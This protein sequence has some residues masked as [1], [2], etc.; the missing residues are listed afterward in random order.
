MGILDPLGGYEEAARLRLGQQPVTKGIKYGGKP[1]TIDR[2]K[3][4]REVCDDTFSHDSIQSCWRKSDI[5]PV[6][7]NADINNGVGFA[8]LP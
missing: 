6:T 1:H 7:Y 8:S 2:M 3:I 4:L 5:F